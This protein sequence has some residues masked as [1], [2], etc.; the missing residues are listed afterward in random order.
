VLWSSNGGDI[1]NNRKRH[2]GRS[3]YFANEMCHFWHVSLFLYYPHIPRLIPHSL[4]LLFSFLSCTVTILGN[5]LL[6]KFTYL[7]KYNFKK[8]CGK[9]IDCME[10]TWNCMES[11]WNPPGIVWNP[12]GIA[13]Q[14]RHHCMPTEKIDYCRES[15]KWSVCGMYLQC[16]CVAWPPGQD[17]PLQWYMS[18]PN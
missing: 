14:P 13:F 10:S 6:C 18:L 1:P 11:T 2:F 16:E 5:F 3:F 9:I 8:Y 17:E 4:P 12:L 7:D 15:V